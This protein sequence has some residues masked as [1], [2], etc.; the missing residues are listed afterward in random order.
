MGQFSIELGVHVGEFSI[1]GGVLLE[2]SMDV[3]KFSIEMGCSN[4]RGSHW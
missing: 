1:K 3:G 4:R 2:G